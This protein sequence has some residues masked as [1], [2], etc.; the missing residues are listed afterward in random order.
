LLQIGNTAAYCPRADE[1]HAQIQNSSYYR[2]L[3]EENA[4]FFDWIRK[5]TGQNYSL[6]NIFNL[7]DVRYIEV[8]SFFSFLQPGRKN[9]T[10]RMLI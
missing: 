5:V 9:S 7:W 2:R 4:E 10:E 3:S 6:A 1:I 8:R